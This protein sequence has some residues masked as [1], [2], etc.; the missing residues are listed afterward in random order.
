MSI[1][2]EKMG[3]ADV[4]FAHGMVQSLRQGNFLYTNDG[5]PSNFTIFGFYESSLKSN[6]KGKRQM[7]LHIMSSNTQGLSEDTI[8]KISKQVVKTPTDFNS[9][10]ITL[11]FFGGACEIFFGEDA[12]GTK[13]IRI[14]HKKLI[15]KR[16]IIKALIETDSTLPTKVLYA[17]DTRFQRHLGECRLATDRSE[18]NDRLVDF[19]DIFEELLDKR[20]NRTLPPTFQQ[21]NDTDAD[22][23]IDDD[24]GTDTGG[25]RK[26]RKRKQRE[27]EDRS[28]VRNNNQL[29][30]FK[31][32]NEDEWKDVFCGRCIDDRPNWKGK[33]N[34]CPR[35]HSRGFCYKNCNHGSSHV[36]EDKIPEP[37]KAEYR[38]YLKKIRGQE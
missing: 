23:N 19:D 28:L 35:W 7:L 12:K 2:F 15:S 16:A 14:F 18:V 38:A 27:E 22:A 29:E 17:V 34:M 8:A 25:P 31:M 24:T 9:M 4:G 26:R 10:E 21:V 36:P 20:F 32:L 13:G 37:K 30:E 6:D 33:E 3:M 1:L 11:S 5:S